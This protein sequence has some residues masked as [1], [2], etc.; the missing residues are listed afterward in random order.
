MRFQ[1]LSTLRRP[2]GATVLLAGALA[3]GACSSMPSVDGITSVFSGSKTAHQAIPAPRP[4]ALNAQPILPAASADLATSNEVHPEIWPL[5]PPAPR[6]PAIEAE[7][8][9]LLSRMT[10]EEK[11]GQM[12]QPD[13]KAVTPQD[14]TRYH[15]GSVL[16]GGSSGPGGEGDLRAP[17]QQ[18][19]AKADEL[20]AASMAVGS[21]RA[22]IPIIWGIDAVHG[23]GH[24]VGATLFPQNIGLG[25]M[26]DPELVRRIGE[27]TAQEIRVTGQ[28]WTFAPTI[29]VVRDDRWGRTYEGY[30]EEPNLVAENATAMVQGLQG[31]PGTADFLRNG[32]VLASIKHF[33]GDGATD[34]G[35]NTGNSS[36]SEAGVRDIL[37]PPYE[38]AIKAG[39]QNV[40][41]SY[42][43]WH[44]TRMHANRGLVTDVLFGRMGFDG[45]VISDYNGLADVPG[46]TVVTCP[47]ST[48]AGIDMIMMA[49]G[50]KTLYGNLINQVGSGQIP[51][52][53]IDEAVARILRVKLRS[54][55]MAAGKPSSRPFA[56][57]YELLGSPE[58][59]A[60]ARQA[61]RESMVLLKND[62]GLL[63]L[64]PRSHVLVAGD[65]AQSM[66]KQTGGWTISWQ[67]MGNSRADFP[68]AATIYEG[69]KANVEAA[70][71][72]VAYSAD[73]SF[74]DKPDVAIVVFGEGPY[75]EGAGDINTL[76][77][78]RGDKRDLKLL[79]NLQA[80]GIPVVAVFLSGRPLYVTPEINASNAFVAA[81]QP[82]SEGEG[83]SD[84]LFAR[85]DGSVAYDF[86]GK[87]SFSWPRA[88]D[89]TALNVGT[90]P[91]DPQF[92]FG[93]GLTYGTP[94]NIGKLFEVPQTSKPIDRTI[95]VENGAPAPTWSAAVV[96]GTDLLAARPLFGSA[97]IQGLTTRQSES[98]V[99]SAAWSGAAP[100]SVVVYGA[101][102]DFMRQRDVSLLMSVRVDA[103][104]AGPVT[105]S[106]GCGP[107][108][109][110]RLDA[111]GIMR[112]AEGKG[113]TTLSVPISCFRAV[114]TDLANIAAP[115]ALASRGSFSLSL[116]SVSLARAETPATC[117]DTPP[118]SSE[119]VYSAPVRQQVGTVHVKKKRVG[120]RHGVRP[121]HRRR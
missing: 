108:C 68:G 21:G 71:G 3:L 26:R 22:A 98:G 6:D 93:Y 36:Y 35:I 5:N 84:L 103:A 4:V 70:G 9:R 54:G 111:T 65:G 83:V 72:S 95:I 33:I 41:V 29:A 80:Q 18:W 55:V 81:W 109:S 94:R 79:Q 107:K 66:S 46:C 121:R 110:G 115:F 48:N 1:C 14:V 90:E 2:R 30:S 73:G 120:H 119:T 56:G 32:H 50:W 12:L 89:Q 59:R 44:G 87:L 118:A 61:V 28:D 17:P 63:P 31:T 49:D 78:Q 19:L 20:Y 86:R 39:A 101:P 117:A 34:Q 74:S 62:G 76:E 77:Y 91:Y 113:W 85:P 10:L 64:S 112:G 43:S 38:S 16:N 116:K 15:L 11:I 104:P 82:G 58:H 24:I 47:Q 96:S 114:G 13:M 53:R 40:M 37:V 88:P 69:I 45:F 102:A 57:R 42:S 27:I 52:A 92:A 105:L 51:M 75:A 23:H 100:A 7:V 25:A 97:S 106:M 8:A 99:L 67:G 60:V